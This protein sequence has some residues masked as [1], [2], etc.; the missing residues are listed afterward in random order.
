MLLFFVGVASAQTFYVNNQTGND[1]NPGTAAQPKLTVGSAIIAAPPGSTISVAYTG[2]NYTEG[3][4]TINKALTFTSTGG[5]PVFVNADLI[6]TVNT[7]FTGP[8]QFKDLTL[9][10]GVVTGASNLTFSGN[11]TRTAGSVDSQINFTAGAHNFTYNGGAAITS[12][13]EL[14]ASSNTTNFGNLTTVVAG[15]ALTLNES[16]TMN[17]ILT[18]VGTLAIGASNTLTIVGASVAHTI[19][20]NVTGGTLAFTLTGNAT[21]T[22]NFNL[23]NITAT[24][25]T[26]GGATLTLLTNTTIGNISASGNATV[27]ADNAATLGALTNSGTGQ[28]S[29]DNAT[30]VGAVNNSGSGNIELFQL[31][32]AATTVASV[33]NTGSGYVLL[34]NPAAI[35]LTVTG[36]IAQSGTGYISVAPIAGA[37]TVNVGGTVTNNPA[38]TL[39][40]ATVNAA[41]N[42]G[43][44]I[45]GDKPTTITGL[46]T[47]SATFSGNAT[48]NNGGAETVWSNA[49]EI[50]FT[51]TT[52]LL[53]LTGG[54]NVSSSASI[55][56]V[57]GG[58]APAASTF[59]NNGGVI[60]SNTTGNIVAAGGFTNSSNFPN[61]TNVTIT[62]NGS[63]VAAAR[64]TGTIGTL[65]TRTG[66]VVNTSSS[67]NGSLNGDI[68]FSFGTGA[69]YGT[70]VTQGPGAAGGD[71]KFGDHTI[72]I[73]G[74]IVSSR[75]AAGADIT[76]VAATALHANT[77]GGYILNSGSSNIDINL[78]SNSTLTV[79]GR[80]ENTGTGS[81]TFTGA[82][83][84]L[85]TL[86]G[87]VIS[88]GTIT[89]PATHTAN[90][91]LS[92]AW[93]VSG[94]TLNLQGAGASNINVSQ[95]VSSPISWTNGTI[96]FTG[97]ATV[98]IGSV[99][100][101][102]GGATTNPTFTSATTT[103]NFVDPIPNVVQNI[104]VGAA[105]PVYPGPFTISNAA[106]IPAPVV[107]FLPSSGSVANLYVLNN[108]L[109]N[110]GVVINSILL[111]GVR[112]NVGKNGIGGGNGNFQNTTGYT[113][114]NGGYVMMSGLNAAQTVNAGVITP[115][116]TFGNFG[117][118]NSAG[119]VGAEV[120]FG[121]AAPLSVF[122][123]DFYLA[124]GDVD[125][126]NTQFNGT[127]PNWPTV[128]RTEGTFTTAPT[129]AAGTK[130]S[131][132]YYGS[133]KVTALEI[134]AGANDLWNLTVST[135]NG[136]VPGKGVVTL[137][138]P[139]TVN[140]TLTIDAN[141][142]LYT[143]G[144]LLTIAGTTAILNGHL[145]DNGGIEVA[146]ASP[147]G[148]AFS[149]SGSMPSIQI[150]NGSLNNSLTLPGL[151]SDAFGADNTLGTGDDD[152]ATYDGNIQFQ[153][154]ADAGSALSVTFSGA[155][156]HF[157]NLTMLGTDQDQTFTLLSNAV[158]S[159]NI[160][161]AA[162]TIA[163]GDFTLTHQGTTPGMTGGATITSNASGK[164][165]FDN[166]GPSTFTITAPAA[167]IAAN[168]EV[169]SDAAFLVTGADLTFG[170]N[171]TLTDKTAGAP[172]A[173]LAI[174]GGR[175]VTAAGAAFTVGTNCNV[176][177]P[178]PGTGILLLDVAA[179]N[180]LLTYTTPAASAVANLTVADNVALAGGVA[181]STLTVGTAMNHTGGD[182]NLGTAELVLAG[183]YT[184]TAGTYTGTNYIT[185]N[186]AGVWNHGPAVAYPKL[187]VS[188]AL[189]IG[190]TGMVTVNDELFL[191]NAVLTQTTAG[192][193]YLT[194]GD[195]N[196]AL[197]QVAGAGNISNVAGQIA[198]TF[199]SPTDYLFSGT[200]SAPNT[201]TWPTAQANNVT[202]NTN[203]GQ[204]V[205]V[206]ANRTINGDVDLKVGTLQWDS[207]VTVTLTDGK[208]ITRRL[209]A[210]ILDRNTNGDATLGGFVVGN[211]NLAYQQTV[212]GDVITTGIEYSVP[213][214]VNNISLLAHTT[215]AGNQ[216]EV[217]IG[218]ARTISGTLSM[219]SILNINFATT[220]T[221]AQT[222][223]AGSTVNSAAN[224]TWAGGLTVNGTWN[225]LAGVTSTGV[226]SGNGT[227]TNNGTINSSGFTSNGTTNLNAGSVL[228][229]TGDATLNNLTVAVLPAVATIN[230]A[231]NLTF[232][233]TLTN[234]GLNL[235]FTGAAAQTVALGGNRV[236]NHLTLNKTANQTV[237]VNGGNLTLSS[238]TPGVL[239]LTKGVLVMTDPYVITLNPAFAGGF[240]TSLGYVRNPAQATDLAHVVG[241][242]GVAVPVN[243]LGRMEWPVGS[244][245]MYRPA[246]ITFTAGNATIAPTTI[247]VSH[248]D[249]TPT[250][251]KNFPIDGG[252]KFAD[253][254]KKLYIAGKAPYYWTFEA[255]TSLGASQK[256]D[257]ELN[258]TNLQKPLENH[259]D[260]RI[261]RR[262]DGDVTVNGWFLEGAANSYS[263]AMYVNSPNVGDT[264]LVVRNIGS[265]GSAISQ[266][267]IFTLGLP[268]LKPVFT[269]TA[270]A[271]VT[272]NENDTYTFTFAAQDQ[273][274]NPS[275]IVYSL[276]GTVPA[277]ASINASTGAFTFHPDY[278]QGSTTPY[279]FVVRAAKSNDPSS[280]IDYT[281]NILVN[282]VNRAPVFTASGQMPNSTVKYGTT[283]PFTY[284]ATDPDGDA[285]T[286]AIVS[287]TPA[288]SVA[289]TITNAMGV[290]QFSWTPAFAD[291]GKSFVIVV[292]VTDGNVVVNSTAATVTVT[293][294]YER[295]DATLSGVVDINDAIKILDYVVGKTT[296]TPE[297]MYYADCNTATGDGVVGAF[298]A[299]YVLKYI[300]NNNSWAG[301]TKAGA[302]QGAVEFSKLSSE[303][304]VVTLPL[305]VANAKGI[306][307]IYAEAEL[308]QLEI[309][310]VTSRLPEGWIVSTSTENGRV[311]IA[312]AGLSP[313][314][315]GI[316]ATIEVKVNNKETAVSVVGNAKLNDELSS[317]LNAKVRE[318]PSEFALSQ[319]Y[320]NPFNPTTTIKFA[321]AND[322]RVNLVVYDMLG[323]KVRTLIDNEQEAGYYSVRWDGTNDF[324]SKVSSG[325]YIYRLQAGNFVQTMK[326]N[327][328]K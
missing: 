37:G 176:T 233:G 237:T 164:L 322:A 211:I 94:G 311:R 34:N 142:H 158:I 62:G 49:G 145:V 21:V 290:G 40:N 192:V 143:N 197:V 252:T 203:A 171:V 110:A 112:L 82:S 113:T 22:G 81:I 269:A 308:G 121:A 132:T 146:L 5:T 199:V 253:P 123:G 242:V 280:Y 80:L 177:A 133:D 109:F 314:S 23:P 85:I 70:S 32:A 191:N 29:G 151:V 169:K 317:S 249:A 319:N 154:G 59:T 57:D 236:I 181:G 187:K 92:G 210:A 292:S 258:G 38:L 73:T 228:T 262:F 76:T 101:T 18:T 28:I 20:G 167:T 56:A 90:I 232:T 310:K 140:G 120:T 1:A 226:I 274:A 74:N 168:V 95:T 50:R 306:T 54:V 11:V 265:V 45:F 251:V 60:F 255:T 131:V 174:D 12:G 298:D 68:D 91:N 14:P 223:P 276:Q 93:T 137:S 89:V 136:A 220:W 256:F 295:G 69:F 99:N 186:S 202:L 65:G 271:N 241:K 307:S 165:L 100:V 185:W 291:N 52:T 321:I 268:S 35:N 2:I 194:I 257:V 170:G 184:R 281:F 215:G 4:I 67:A 239:T 296:L 163:L 273:D 139:A 155:G 284:A 304:G 283:L 16:K 229:L 299:A 275:T 134:P 106:N 36:N 150:N 193:S 323:Q 157:N 44:I 41:S 24:K 86:G 47:N 166:V 105:N 88:N 96:N 309:G 30:T 78:A 75:T 3:N 188:A 124:E 285:L 104:Y 190:A 160:T 33:T 231:N 224:T 71:I 278:T 303:N 66:A 244:A 10:T 207:P 107:R 138:A 152:F 305:V 204:I 149:G 316:F 26:A 216:T 72:D 213:T 300:A 6:V 245:T 219:A 288:P 234:A 230:T 209:N 264:L 263:N 115:G 162:G 128:Y 324:G 272:I 301:V 195:A 42:R 15:T 235:N 125:L 277:N 63:I 9:T 214:T 225:N 227:I 108:V 328:M 218:F 254:S 282:N 206:G 315:D 313:I 8:F 43:V 293:A 297:A 130:I 13:F 126:T 248:V 221:L 198:P 286:Y 135:T 55:T 318:I 148:T 79:T 98:N 205:T 48:R 312:A 153:A 147:T 238:A 111:D 27:L 25:S 87:I 267:A 179:P 178:A 116:A 182:I 39:T 53:T 208:T 83:A 161:H 180:T 51:N 289:P 31:S 259:N 217:N 46:V 97:V 270:P 250:G 266:K 247:I 327:L 183:N 114:A 103:L 19:G 17:G 77:V 141:Q 117:V 200:S 129:L 127:A 294:K 7:A 325:I 212:A 260:L 240:I 326:M 119:L 122:T 196:G 279:T 118:D 175:T 189:N 84:G 201:F 61:V 58:L 64:T 173:S 302:T 320:P 287:V 246:A 102:I 243:T 222:I 159:G 144:N 261:I 156:P 172:G